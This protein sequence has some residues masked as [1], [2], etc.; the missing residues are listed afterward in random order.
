[1]AD[2]KKSESIWSNS[3]I[4]SAIISS[5]VVAIIPGLLWHLG[6]HALTISAV[7]YLLIEPESKR[8]K[9]LEKI[10]KKVLAESSELR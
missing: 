1:M 10:M 6:H 5:A 9:R 3:D 7:V 4:F 8:Q 2:N